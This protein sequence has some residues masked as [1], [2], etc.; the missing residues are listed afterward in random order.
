METYQ[1]IRKERSAGLA[2]V[3]AFPGNSELNRDIRKVVE[4]L[5]L[6]PKIAHS[7]EDAS[8]PT[9]V[10][11][12]RPVPRPASNQKRASRAWPMM[13]IGAFLAVALASVSGGWALSGYHLRVE[14]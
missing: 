12:P 4:K 7:G 8:P 11:T 14:Q 10:K 5:G 6:A 9:S 2:E 1:A 13:T 3:I